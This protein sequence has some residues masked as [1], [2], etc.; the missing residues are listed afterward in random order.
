MVLIPSCISLFHSKDILPKYWCFIFIEM[1]TRVVSI[2]SP[3]LRCF[4]I[5]K[6]IRI[7]KM[8]QRA[9]NFN[10]LRFFVNVVIEIN[11]YT[12]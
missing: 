12:S 9:K 11:C 1:L 6:T 3:F 2:K 5:N 4:F 10:Y 7:A 8:K